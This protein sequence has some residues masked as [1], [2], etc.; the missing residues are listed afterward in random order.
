[1]VGHVHESVMERQPTRCCHLPTQS[2]L[3]FDCQG[4]DKRRTTQR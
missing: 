3:V 2:G 1:M 4:D